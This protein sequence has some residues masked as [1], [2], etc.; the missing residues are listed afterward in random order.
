M[1][2]RSDEAET[3]R[4]GDEGHETDNSQ[5]QPATTEDDTRGDEGNA[6]DCP[7]TSSHGRLHKAHQF[8][9]VPPIYPQGYSV[10]LRPGGVY[11][12]N[13]N[14][15]ATRNVDQADQHWDLDELSDDLCKA[16]PLATRHS[17]SLPCPAERR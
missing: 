14:E 6:K 5:S 4:S 13:A 9:H 16:G 2:Q 10:Q 7:D 1:E 8:P 17:E 11:S 3:C 12:S 15:P